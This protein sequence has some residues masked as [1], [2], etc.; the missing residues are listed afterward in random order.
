MEFQSYVLIAMY[1][2]LIYYMNTANNSYNINSTV[3]IVNQGNGILLKCSA[4]TL[5]LK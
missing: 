2:I 1:T 3:T 4:V 5:I